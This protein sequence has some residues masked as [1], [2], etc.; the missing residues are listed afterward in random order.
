M[1]CTGGVLSDLWNGL[2]KPFFHGDGHLAG[3]ADAGQREGG[4]LG[5]LGPLM[6]QVSCARRDQ[7]RAARAMGESGILIVSQAGRGSRSAAHNWLLI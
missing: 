3:R 6:I 1:P 7:M 5:Q 2:E 4:N